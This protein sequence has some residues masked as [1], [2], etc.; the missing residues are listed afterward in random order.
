[1]DTE[2]AAW[3]SPTQNLGSSAPRRSG[4][5]REMSLWSLCLHERS[6]PS[7]PPVNWTQSFLH[8]PGAPPLYSRLLLSPP[9]C[10]RKPRAEPARVPHNGRISRTPSTRTGSVYLESV[11]LSLERD[12]V[13][14]NQNCSIGHQP[15]GLGPA[16]TR[17][18]VDDCATYECGRTHS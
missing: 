1:M 4:Q 12:C 13:G 2:P 5:R 18:Q 10:H 7:L 15:S 8:G 16:R 6:S 14:Q 11:P 9:N 17:R 3:S